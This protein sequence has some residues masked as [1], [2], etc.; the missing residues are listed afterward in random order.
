MAQHKVLVID[1]NPVVVRMNESLLKSAGYEVIVARD[2]EEGLS[3][4][5]TQQPAVI[6][7]DLIL[8]K[9]HG[10]E[11]CQRLKADPQTAKIPVIVVTGTGL[12]DVVRSEPELGV[13]GYLSKPYGL[14]EL[15]AAIKKVVGFETEK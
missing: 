13:A 10:F 9:M 12:E 3:A 6:L 4:A 5:R 8:P 15:E 7:L 11:V 1:D 14:E 2:G